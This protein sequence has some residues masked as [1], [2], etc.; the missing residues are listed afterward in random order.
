MNKIAPAT[1]AMSGTG[2]ADST[3]FDDLALIGALVFGGPL[4]DMPLDGAERGN[5]PV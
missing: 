3:V 2:T 5:P 1:P 4:P